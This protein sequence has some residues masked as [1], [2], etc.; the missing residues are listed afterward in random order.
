MWGGQKEM[1]LKAGASHWNAVSQALLIFAA[2]STASSLRRAAATLFRAGR[3]I[4]SLLLPFEYWRISRS[5][6]SGSGWLIAFSQRARHYSPL[7][8]TI[9]AHETL[10]ECQ[11]FI[12]GFHPVQQG[13]AFHPLTVPRNSAAFM[14]WPPRFDA[15]LSGPSRWRLAHLE[16]PAPRTDRVIV[17]RSSEAMYCV[18]MKVCGIR[19]VNPTQDHTVSPART[20]DWYPRR[21]PH[22]LGL[23][24]MKFES[25]FV[26]LS[27][28]CFGEFVVHVYL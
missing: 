13:G 2:C 8:K 25:N 20:N 7:F 22:P 23:L 16:R 3:R 11:G 6:C 26:R 17:S 12:P 28:F 14:R 24:V 9:L 21:V 19:N 10:I 15:T 5:S 27:Q 4:V 1:I 18:E